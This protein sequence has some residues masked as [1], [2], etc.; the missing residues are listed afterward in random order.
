MGPMA[1]R[2]EL[3]WT[4]MRDD[5]L[6]DV[7]FCDLKLRLDETPLADRIE[8]LYGELA[9]RDLTFRPHFWLAEEWF[10]PDGVPGVAIPFY[11]AHPRLTK[12]EYQQMFEVEGGTD[13]W[14]MR[15]LRHETGHA[16]DTA[17]RLHRRKIWRQHFGVFGRAYPK[18]YTPRPQSRRYVLHLDWWYAQC[19]PAEDYAETFAVWLRP[20]SKWR[21][22][23]A[24]WPALKKLEAVDQLMAS[25][26]GTTPPVRSRRQIE[27]LS[28]NRTTLREHYAAKRAHYGVDVPAFY[29][30]DL[31]RLFTRTPGGG[32]RRRTAA[33]FLRR[34]APEL[35][36]VCARGTGEHPYFIAQLVQEMVRRCRELNLY[37]DVPER[38]VMLDVAVLITVQT[39]NYLH[40][41]QHK[42]PV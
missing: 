20:R 19:H 5:E 18:Y 40:S 6:L 16:I 33:A 14:C 4:E 23:Y 12:L 35:C 26:A 38:Q 42:V 31:Q 13:R 39:V 25:I 15:L 7:R 17:Y 41:G 34:A 11:L 30:G 27:P 24:G 9:R 21:R 22:E 32:K 36:Q 37:V 28:T 8:R 1:G 29:D 3:K 10:S 2:T